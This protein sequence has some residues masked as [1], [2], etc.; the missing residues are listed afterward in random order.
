MAI[1]KITHIFAYLREFR[2]F[3]RNFRNKTLQPI[4]SSTSGDIL[5]ITKFDVCFKMTKNTFFKVVFQSTLKN[6]FFVI[7]KHKSNFVMIKMS[8]EV[9]EPIG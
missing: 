5:I 2:S 4:G 7:L 6:V 1:V 8:P 3:Q 9:E